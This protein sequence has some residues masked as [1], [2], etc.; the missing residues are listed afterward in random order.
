MFVPTSSGVRKVTSPMLLAT[1]ADPETVRRGAV[2]RQP[3]A[4]DDFRRS[5]PQRHGGRPGGCPLIA[6]RRYSLVLVAALVLACIVPAAAYLKLGTRVGNRT[7]DAG[8]AAVP[9]P[10]LRHQSRRG[11]RHRAA[12]P[13]C[14]AAGVQQLARRAEHPDLVAVRR[15]HAGEPDL[16]R[17]RDGARLPESTRPRSHARR[18]QLLH[19]H[20]DRRDR[21]V[22]HLLQFLVHL[23]DRGRRHDRAVRRR[24]DRAARDRPSARPVALGARR[25][26]AARRRP[27]RARAPSR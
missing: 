22:G 25:D 1:S 24:L 14:R 18:D 12:V 7:V 9:D 20:D 4:L 10:L 8:V 15:L 23:V 13:D 17:R 2:T 27:T 5:D 11:R 19:R 6:V 21:R 16:R 3:M 26:R